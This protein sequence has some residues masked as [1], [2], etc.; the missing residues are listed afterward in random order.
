MAALSTVWAQ[1]T[2]LPIGRSEKPA[3]YPPESTRGTRCFACNKCLNTKRFFHLSTETVHRY[4]LLL[5]VYIR[6]KVNQ[7][8][9]CVE[10]INEQTSQPRTR[11]S[12]A[13]IDVM[14][15]PRNVAPMRVYGTHMPRAVTKLT[16]RRCSHAG[17]MSPLEPSPGRS[18]VC[19]I[20]S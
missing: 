3:S 2:G 13:N 19:F 14:G 15:S 10:P 12:S 17:I 18:V 4:L 7:P 6:K 20:Y 11:P 1:V 5:S 8:V 9:D 16:C